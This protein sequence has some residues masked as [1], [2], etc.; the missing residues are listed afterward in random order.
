MLLVKFEECPLPA[1]PRGSFDAAGDGVNITLWGHSPTFISAIA[2]YLGFKIDCVL[3][4]ASNAEAWLAFTPTLS[5]CHMHQL[6]CH[7]FSTDVIFPFL[8]FTIHPTL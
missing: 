3:E 6:T 2:E 4:Y 7:C 1:R 5:I 8:D